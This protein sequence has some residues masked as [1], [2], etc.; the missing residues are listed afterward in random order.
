MLE[1]PYQL[2]SVHQDPSDFCAE[3]A[4]N[5]LIKLTLFWKVNSSEL[6][7]LGLPSGLK[8]WKTSTVFSSKRHLSM[9]SVLLVLK[10]TGVTEN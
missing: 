9:R 10:E 4:F 5:E 6:L 8:F 3:R 1:V 7:V 2:L